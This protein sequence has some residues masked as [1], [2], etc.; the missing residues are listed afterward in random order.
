MASPAKKYNPI[1]KQKANTIAEF[2]ANSFFDNQLIFLISL[3]IPF[4]VNQSRNFTPNPP[5][6]VSLCKVWRPHLLQ[7]LFSSN[8]FTLTRLFLVIV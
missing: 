2:W 6:L 7:Y 3:L 4:K 5:Y 1:I 8:L